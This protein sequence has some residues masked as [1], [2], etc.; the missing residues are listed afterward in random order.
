MEDDNLARKM[1][2]KDDITP[3]DTTNLTITQDQE[4]NNDSF[5]LVWSKKKK[6]KT[7]QRRATLATPDA[8]DE[9]NAPEESPPPPNPIPEGVDA[10]NTQLECR[11]SVI[12]SVPASTEPW[13]AF[14]DLLEQ[15]LKSIQ[16]QTT[17]KLFITPWD[18][19]LA[20]SKN[21]IKK[22]ND[23]PEGSAKKWK[24]YA[25][26]FSGYPNPKRGK[27]SKVYLK[28]RFVT[29]A[30]QDMPFNLENMGQELSK[31]LAE[32]MTVSLAKKPYACQAVKPE[33]IGW[34]FGSTKSIGSKKLVP[35]I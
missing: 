20:E 18:Q 27:P 19:E 10:I 4:A 33:C 29:N 35:A 30:P 25:T 7:T 22:P 26:Y 15:F 28:V 21:L 2:A 8:V 6:S 31:S 24:M 5:T 14:T 13:K 23:F 1:P 3:N 11:Y 32:E 34:L 9:N 12:V 17:K 16:E